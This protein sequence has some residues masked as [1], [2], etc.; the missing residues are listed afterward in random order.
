[1]TIYEKTQ[2]IF[3]EAEEKQRIEWENDTDSLREQTLIEAN[4]IIA[5]I[6][7]KILELADYNGHYEEW[8]LQ[9]DEACAMARM[10]LP[11]FSQN[12]KKENPKWEEEFNANAERV[13]ANANLM[14]A[15]PIMLKA[16]LAAKKGDTS[17]ID[18]AIAHAMGEKKWTD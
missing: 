9:S 4:N 3:R 15:S 6:E 14:Q 5:E 12:Y 2:K 1:M 18:Y 7:K 13:Q 10:Q 11:H 17:L 16:L 8:H